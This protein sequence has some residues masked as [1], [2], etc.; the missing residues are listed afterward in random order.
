MRGGSMGGEDG[1]SVTGSNEGP[2]TIG[3]LTSAFDNAI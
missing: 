1:R 3:K 2:K